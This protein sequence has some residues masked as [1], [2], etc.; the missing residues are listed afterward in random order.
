MHGRYMWRKSLFAYGNSFMLVF[1]PRL[2]SINA[3]YWIFSVMVVVLSGLRS[4][5][6]TNEEFEIK[7]SHTLQRWGAKCRKIQRNKEKKTHT[8][9]LT[10]KAVYF[11]SSSKLINR[12]H[13][14]GEESKK[15]HSRLVSASASQ[16]A[17]SGKNGPFLWLMSKSG[18]EW[19]PKVRGNPTGM[20]SKKQN[21][22]R[23]S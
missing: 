11:L 21:S 16:G 17:S 18:S 15:I 22:L 7:T 10:H 14:V 8:L 12:L 6:N 1:Y 5:C 9:T 3:R 20:R 2:S 23:A 4:A 19:S 13:E